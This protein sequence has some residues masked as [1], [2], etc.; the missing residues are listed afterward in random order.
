MKHIDLEQFDGITPGD[1]R[2]TDGGIIDNGPGAPPSEYREIADVYGADEYDNRPIAPDLD[3][4]IANAKAIAAIPA[5][6]AELREMRVREV[7]LLT[8]IER[9]RDEAERMSNGKI[10]RDVCDF[11]AQVQWA[12]KMRAYQR[13]LDLLNKGDETD[14]TH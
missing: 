9:W 3:V 4:A 5:L 10:G 1:W 7:A 8:T 13:V 2:Y 11:N 12:D 6:I 14:E